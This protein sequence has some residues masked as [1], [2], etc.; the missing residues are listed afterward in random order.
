[1]R[2][3]ENSFFYGIFAHLKDAYLFQNLNFALRSK[4]PEIKQYKLINDKFASTPQQVNI[5]L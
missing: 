5:L 3:S 1:M 4:L 2:Y